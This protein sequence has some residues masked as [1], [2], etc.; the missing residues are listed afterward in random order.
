MWLVDFH[1]RPLHGSVLHNDI[2]HLVGQ[3]LKK[4]KAIAIDVA[5]NLLGNGAIVERCR[6][7][8]PV[9]RFCGIVGQA[10]IDDNVL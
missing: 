9:D 1:L 3:A 8:V 5:D 2:E 4:R 6:N 7:L 10:D